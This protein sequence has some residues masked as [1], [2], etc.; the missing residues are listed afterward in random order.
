MKGTI[1]QNLGASR[2]VV[3]VRS[4]VQPLADEIQKY[5]DLYQA[6]IPKITEAYGVLNE[7]RGAYQAALDAVRVVAADYE[8]CRLDFS[9]TNCINDG[10]AA[11]ENAYS[12]ADSACLDIESGIGECDPDCQRERERCHDAAV[13]ARTACLS[14]VAIDCA[15]AEYAHVLECLTIYRKMFV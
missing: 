7:R 13:R 5:R 9:S 11:C 15:E 1:R 2:Y 3:G 12:E 8:L 6:T 14:L 4:A 10:N